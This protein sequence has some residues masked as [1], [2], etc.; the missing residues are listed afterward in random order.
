MALVKA[1]KR[2]PAWALA[3]LLSI[4]YAVIYV[5]AGWELFRPELLFG[6]CVWGDP[7]ITANCKNI[8][9][10]SHSAAFV[11]DTLMTGLVV[12]FYCK[13]KTTSR[14]W[15]VYSAMGFIIFVHGFLHWFLQQDIMKIQVNCYNPDIDDNVDKIGTA[16]F[17]AFSFILALV[18][19]GFG[20]GLDK[21]TF[22]F[23]FA[24]SGA[25]VALTKNVQGDLFLPGLFV[26]VHPISCLTGLLS[27]QEGLF[28]PLVAKWFALSTL[29]GIIELAACPSILKPIGGHLW[30]D[31]TLH[32]SV[33]SSLPY[34]WPSVPKKRKN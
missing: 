31:I 13:D 26:L 10:N 5:F 28:N 6:F 19:L 29:V 30:Y 27:N 4:I 8:P 34:F 16:F 33:I 20:F 23:A 15:M 9:L 12:F 2:K 24:F 11:V 21:A 3:L 17:A 18:I 32:I 22:G 7:E 14:N 25:V 1:L